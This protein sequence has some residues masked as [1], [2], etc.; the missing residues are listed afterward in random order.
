MR[1]QNLSH[2]L[3][4]HSKLLYVLVAGLIFILLWANYYQID[5][6]TR[7]SGKV[8]ASSRIQ[9][10]QAANGGVLA[11]LFV[12]EGDIVEK[13]QLLASLDKTSFAASVNEL[14]AR[15]VNLQAQVTRLRASL[16]NK[17]TLIFAP[18]V[19]QYKEVVE[20]QTQIFVQ[21]KQG[22]LDE[23]R[24]LKRAFDL[25]SQEAKVVEDLYRSG[26]V[27]QSDVIRVEKMKNEAESKLV[28]RRNKQLEDLSIELAKVDDDLRQ[29]IEV[30]K[31]RQ[32][33][34]EN[35]EFR[36]VLPGIVKNV[37]I[38][39]IG[40]VLRAGEELMQI[41][42]TN[43]ELIVEAKVLPSDIAGLHKGLNAS[44]RFDPFDFTIFGG[45]NGKVNYVSGDTLVED[46][47][48]GEQTYY[49][50]HI[51]LDGYPVTTT[52][53]KEIDLLPGMTAQVDIRTGKRSVL[54]YLL[55][56]IRKTLDQS[57][58]ER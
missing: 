34:L 47:P 41:I 27:Q 42:P 39:T 33:Q 1:N 4:R 16:L 12:K 18:E 55:K 38:T 35:S 3:N 11:Q 10:I 56:P 21:K 14:N 58:T 44:V 17:E 19:A 8:I 46:T 52:R 20:L 23:I 22:F 29:N 5:E 51:K 2:E 9:I 7:A 28:N 36:A 53:N 37:R 13:G 24:T 25:S 49:R 40:G 50:V 43:D 31:Q 30:R 6:V 54:T 15:I 26:D 48:K 57:L 45:V 32:E